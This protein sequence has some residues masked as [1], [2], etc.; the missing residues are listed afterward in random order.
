MSAAGLE[1]LARRFFGAYGAGELETMR[2]LLAS[3]AVSW[4]T[5]AEGHADRVE[6][7]EG[8]MAR[9]PETSDAT[10]S[11]KIT[12]VLAIDRCRVLT[13]IEIKAERGGRTLHNFAAFLARAEDGR[14]AE[15]WMVE[16][17]P[18]YSDEFWS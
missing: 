2:E 13:A 7:R 12:Q 1:Q 11:T 15:L 6:G 9:L 18:A 14:I 5:N 8:F 3:D 16:A 17:R 4:I 10:L